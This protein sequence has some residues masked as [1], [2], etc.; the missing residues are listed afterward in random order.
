M[1]ILIA[2]MVCAQDNLETDL[3]ELSITIN[4]SVAADEVVSDRAT[5]YLMDRLRALDQVELVE[6][7]PDFSVDVIVVED[8]LESGIRTGFIASIVV[9]E[10]KIDVADL[11]R[12]LR[13]DLDP[14]VS[15]A[16]SS[17]FDDSMR[18]LGHKVLIDPNLVTL[19][20][21]I[22]AYVNVE[23]VEETKKSYRHALDQLDSA[24]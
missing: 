1:S 13:V 4:L 20:E 2:L 7:D 22:C 18:Y 11:M 17:E 5:I 19:C 8:T 24:E 16:L 15:K 14:R 6:N 3:N 10:A 23:Y 21:R 9:R 12:I